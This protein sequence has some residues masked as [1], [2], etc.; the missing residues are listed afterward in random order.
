MFN[1]LQNKIIALVVGLLIVLSVIFVA[2][3]NVNQG[4]IALLK[5]DLARTE[6]SRENLQMDLTS[7]TEQLEVDELEKIKMRDSAVLL[8]KTFSAREQHRAAIK[9][10]FAESNKALKKIFD[11]TTDEKTISWSNTPI[12]VDINR[13][14]EQSA[15]CANSHRN[16]DSL[17][18]PAKGT[19]KPMLST[20]LLQHN[21]SRAF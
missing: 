18:V 20:G 10:D 4:Q 8:A 13:V 9:N 3:F 21:E 14:L 2:V 15:K 16:K 11:E 6:Q 17:C 7:I 19:D 1:T 5:S 12:P